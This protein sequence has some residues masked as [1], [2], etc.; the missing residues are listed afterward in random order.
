MKTSKLRDMTDEELSKELGDLRRSLFN[1]R[2]Q[3]A[4]G[5]L[6]KSHKLGET[7]RDIARV[8]TIIGERASA[9]EEEAR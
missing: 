4:T 8:M 6:E 1:L 9:A 3:K 5:Q 2:V 7:S